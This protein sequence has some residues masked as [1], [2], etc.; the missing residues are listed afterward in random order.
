MI[1]KDNYR[2]KF[3]IIKAIIDNKKY[4]Q[5]FFQR[6]TDN[7]LLWMGCGHATTE[8]LST[9]NGLRIDEAKLILDIIEGKNIVLNDEH[10]I[11]SNNI[12]KKVMLYDEEKHIAANKIKNYWFNCK[13]NP[14]Y[15]L[16]HKLLSLSYDKI[17]ST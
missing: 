14:E 15:K 10:R 2:R 9:Y 12:N 6:Y 8:F 13:F 3:L 7:N 16:C 1:G 11:S 5:T 17:I 4:M